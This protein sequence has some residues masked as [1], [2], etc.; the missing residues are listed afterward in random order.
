[1][2]TL[3]VARYWA[4]AVPVYLIV[5]LVVFV[6][7]YVGTNFLLVPNLAEQRTVTGT[8]V[9]VCICV[10]HKLLSWKNSGVLSSISSPITST[11][12]T[13]DVFPHSCG[14][15]PCRWPFSPSTASRRT[16]QNLHPSSPRH[17]HQR[18]QQKDVQIWTTGL[19]QTSPRLLM[20][21][22]YVWASSC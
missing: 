1:M 3:F 18:G 20:T 2:S 19:I 17:S 15:F 10:C 5:C 21:L 16:T 9:Y 22:L 12:S 6:C 11:D 13:A 8:P 7:L 14:C 4:V